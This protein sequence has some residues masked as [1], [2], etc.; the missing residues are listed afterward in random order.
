MPI[1]RLP[2]D[3]SPT[4]SVMEALRPTRS[5]I[6]PNRNPPNGRATN[7]TA[8][9][10]KVESTADAGSALLNNWLAMNGVNVA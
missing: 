3:A 2:S 1:I 6:Q 8:K 4:A 5:P 9:I 7:P 10:A